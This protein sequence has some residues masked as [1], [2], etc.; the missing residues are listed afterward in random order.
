MPLLALYL[1]LAAYLAG[2][3]LGLAYL[4]RGIPTAPP[5]ARWLAA[6]GF[7]AHSLFL[8]WWGLAHRRPPA[9][10]TFEALVALLWSIVLAFFILDHSLRLRALPAFVLPPVA[11]CGI[12]IA[13]LVPP[14]APP[15]PGARTWWVHV[16][17][18]TSLA[19]VASFVV[20]SAVAL[21][22][23]LQRRQ[24]KRKAL[25]PLMQRL[26]SLDALDRLNY[27]AITLGFPLFTLSLV[28][29]VV[30]AVSKDPAWWS[31]WTVALSLLIWVL[32]A[33]LLH[34][35]I[36]AGR[37]GPRVAYLTLAAFVLALLVV[38]GIAFLGDQLHTL[39]L[40]PA[41]EVR[42]HAP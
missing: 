34:V 10:A 18:L 28:A 24:L 4:V 6:A 39:S 36:G 41:P 17:A 7:A 30:L 11:A 5:R 31:R 38:C 23:L 37:R 21:M 25:G 2:A 29:G 40:G 27:R 14:H 42:P 16:H 19:G 22:Y 15:S 3:A 12:L 20:A 35:R 1:A 13:A 26:P 32:Y 33:L 9:Y 8:L